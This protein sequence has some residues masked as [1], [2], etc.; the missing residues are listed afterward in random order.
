MISCFTIALCPSYDFVGN[1]QRHLRYVLSQ[2]F[3]SSNTLS[4]LIVF[5]KTNIM[6]EDTYNLNKHTQ[7]ICPTFIFI[8]RYQMVNVYYE[9]IS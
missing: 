1:I 3:S 9:P 4:T 2:E 8:R 6:S 7:L 5:D